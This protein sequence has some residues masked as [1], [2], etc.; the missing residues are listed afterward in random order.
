MPGHFYGRAKFHKP[1]VP[2]D[3]SLPW[4]IH[5]N[6]ILPKDD[7][8]IKPYILDIYFLPSTLSFIDKTKE[9]KPTNDF[10][11]ASFDVTS[12]F[13]KVPVDLVI[14]DIADKLFS[15]NVAPELPFLH[16]KKNSYSKHSCRTFKT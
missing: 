3:Q 13:T 5:L 16:S 10:K 6:I 1:V 15:C 14:D 7:F 12:L 4:L 9:L 2:F 11:L 8:L